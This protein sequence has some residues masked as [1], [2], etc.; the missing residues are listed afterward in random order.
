[1][2]EIKEK[3]PE[4]FVQGLNSLVEKSRREDA[5]NEGV[6][7][8]S[9]AEDTPRLQTLEQIG[10]TAALSQESHELYLQPKTLNSGVVIIGEGISFRRGYIDGLKHF[11]AEHKIA[12]LGMWTTPDILTGDDGL[13]RYLGGLRREKPNIVREYSTRE[14]T[15]ELISSKKELELP[16]SLQ[17]M[18]IR[19]MSR[20]AG[21][22]LGFAVG[23]TRDFDMALGALEIPTDNLSYEAFMAGL[24]TDSKALPVKQKPYGD[25]KYI[26][27]K[28]EDSLG[29]QLRVY[30][31]IDEMAYQAGLRIWLHAQELIDVPTWVIR[32]PEALRAFKA[33][34]S[35]EILPEYSLQL[36]TDPLFPREYPYEKK[37]INNVLPFKEL[38]DKLE[39][40]NDRPNPFEE[41]RRLGKMAYQLGLTARIKMEAK[42]R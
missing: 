42:S 29:S 21:Y 16:R 40:F 32:H 14:S 30:E 37:I 38:N 3:L 26:D 2:K 6:K 10:I 33:G 31:T 19:S 1:M 36:R 35:G 4:G 39:L 22:R 34:L 9:Q 15:K 8:G 5:Y 24:R 18:R 23:V 13:Q 27:F 25:E 20:R 41:T 12:G 28:D 11:I 7:S 17:E